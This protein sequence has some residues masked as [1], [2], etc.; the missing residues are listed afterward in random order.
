MQKVTAYIIASNEAEKIRA[1]I[2]SVRWTNEIIVAD[3]WSTDGT[4]EV[5]QEL[6]GC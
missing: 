4:A 1:A 5:A 2:E 6:R 3:F